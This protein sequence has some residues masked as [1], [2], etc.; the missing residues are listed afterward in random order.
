MFSSEMSFHLSLLLNKINYHKRYFLSYK[1]WY[2]FA[3][4]IKNIFY[5]SFNYCL[6]GSLAIIYYYDLKL[7]R[8]C[9]FLMVIKHSEILAFDVF[10]ILY[11]KINLCL[12]F[13]SIIISIAIVDKLSLLVSSLRFS[14]LS[15]TEKKGSIFTFFASF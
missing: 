14:K 5:I 13:L 8:K 11:C 10:E 9:R 1:N 4:M 12:M 6:Y 7:C 2:L 3:F 15:F